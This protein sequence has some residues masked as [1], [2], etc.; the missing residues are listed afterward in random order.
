MYPYLLAYIRESEH[1][2]MCGDKVKKYVGVI[3]I[4]GTKQKKK[5]KR[6]GVFSENLENVE[7]DQK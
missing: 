7:M 6:N 3:R 4:H 1:L 2:C 5:H